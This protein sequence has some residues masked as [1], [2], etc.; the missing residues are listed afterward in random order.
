MLVGV[1]LAV[2]AGAMVS[3]QETP[4]PRPVGDGP[5]LPYHSIEGTGGVFITPT[6]YLVNPGPPDTVFGKPAVSTHFALIGDKDFESITFTW[7]LWRRLELGYGLDR[8]GLDDLPRDIRRATGVD[9]GTHDIHLHHFNA[10]FNVI[11]ENQWDQKWLPAVTAGAHYKYND[12]VKAIDRRLGG[13]L[14]GIGMDDNEGV[15]FT[16][17]AS[18]T[19][20]CLPRPVILSAG[21][22]ASK[23]AQLGFL[24]FTDDYRVTFEGSVVTLLSNKFVLA[25]EYRQKPDEL[26]RVPGLIGPEDDWWDV[27]LGYIINDR[28]SVAAG[29]G[30]FG[31]VANHSDQMVYACCL[32][33]EF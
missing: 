16:L 8:L 11:E 33:Y 10:R 26:K 18:K 7:T 14:T 28:L 4:E 30:N 17:T 19:L 13:A 20:T 31:T 22:R 1:A 29:V 25:A 23:G 9:I 12:S 32:K 5:P 15:D 21:A 24:G 2:L 6:A 27:C 3:A